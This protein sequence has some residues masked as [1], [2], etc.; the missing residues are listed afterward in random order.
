M[1]RYNSVSA[2]GSITG[3]NSI[4]TPNSGLLTTITSGGTVTVPNPVYYAGAIQTFYNASGGS[5]TLTTPSGVFTGISASGNA[6]QVISNTAIITI[7]SDGTN[8]I[9]QS[10]LGGSVTATSLTVTGAVTANPVNASISL[11]PTGTGIVT[12]A[13]STGNPGNIDN[14][15]IGASTK[16]TGAFTTLTSNGATTFTSSGTITLGTAASGAVQV[17]N[18]VGIGGGITVANDSYFG[19][20][21]GIGTVGPV[22]LLHASGAYPQVVLNNTSAGSGSLMLFGDAGTFKQAIGHLTSTN[23]LQFG[24]GG[25][26]TN[27]TFNGTTGM[28]LTNTGLLGIGVTPTY[29]LHVVT[30]TGNPAAFNSSTS[31][32][33]NIYLTCSNAS[34][35]VSGY[36]GPNAWN[37]NVF[38]IGSSTNHAL[39]FT[40]NGTQRAQIDT[41]GH[42]LP[43][44]DNAYDMGNG[45][46]RWRNVYTGDL[47]LSNKGSA[48]SV[49]GTNGDWT[50][51]E[52]ETDLFILNN[53]TGKRFKFK[54]EEI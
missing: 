51:Q 18:G 2:T 9:V 47:H 42:F 12:I 44:S 54:L 41:S 23:Y 27:G 34:T 52:G 31:G 7:V 10:F 14:M 38:G 1:A 13:S 25:T 6:N 16:G 21:V 45:S 29:G 50:I 15:N 11:Q 43:M 24:Y 19:G 28:T 17:T 49:D 4:A 40:T 32:G 36:M 8:Y 26:G 3:G 48:N 5:A 35:P 39:Q 22:G 53:K 30:T 46:Y 37:N 33:G 20:K